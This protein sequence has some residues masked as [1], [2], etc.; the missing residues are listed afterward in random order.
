MEQKSW[1]AVGVLAAIIIIGV[2]IVS[3]TGDKEEIV[4]QPVNT[5]R[6]LIVEEQPVVEP[7]EV[8]SE[9]V[10]TTTPP[11]AV[12]PASAPSIATS[13]P[14][15]PTTANTPTTNAP[16]VASYT[17]AQVSVH[18]SANDC[19][20]VVRGNVYNVTSFV[21]RHPGGVESIS[22]VCGRDG[23][24]FFEDQHGGQKSPESVLASLKVGV[25]VR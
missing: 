13:S 19:W 20:T 15:K 18:A 12:V 23:T 10:A 1:I 4:E 6:S 5:D 3:S 9:I 17:L 22:Q 11:A 16:A 24:A 21:R 7:T 8:E 2:A 25:L 14:S